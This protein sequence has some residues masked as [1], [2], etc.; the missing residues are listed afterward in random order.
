MQV[1]INE[2]SL[3]GQFNA[4]NVE[5]GIKSFIATLKILD[6]IKGQESIFRSNLFFNEE[7]ISG[8]HFNSMLAANGDLL[9]GFLN[10]LK[11]ASKWQDSQ[12]HDPEDLYSWNQDIVSD[13][14]VAELAA[15]KFQNSTLV[16]VLL[17]FVSSTYSY[18]TAISVLKNLND[19]VK[20]DCS[21]SE[22]SLI[23]LLRKY[24][25]ISQHDK[26]NEALKVPPFDDQTIL[27]T[28]RFE[29]TVYKNKGRRAYRLIGTSQLWAVDDSEGHLFGKP[30][31]EVFN[32]IDGAHMG[33]SVYNEINLEDKY[34]RNRKINL[35]RT[36]PIE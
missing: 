7:A 25:L 26:Y 24:N 20:I 23:A 34:K 33:T 1:F 35:A 22:N 32:E 4:A 6:K 27:A 18:D 31:I 21:H 19:E 36:Y 11:S 28:D 14:S 30:H 12:V 2:K 15:R 9:N 17:N 29:I 8:V 10:N 5:N 13:S 3:Q 16:S